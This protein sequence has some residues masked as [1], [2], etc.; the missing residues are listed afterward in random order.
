[1]YQLK[2]R[3]FFTW[4]TVCTGLTQNVLVHCSVVPDLDPTIFCHPRSRILYKK[5]MC[6]ISLTFFT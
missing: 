3:A 2:Y 6:K 5:E 4:N 1:M